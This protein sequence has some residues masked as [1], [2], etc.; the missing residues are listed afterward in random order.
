[1]FEKLCEA[2]GIRFKRIIPRADDKNADYKIS[3]HLNTLRL[4]DI[5]G[6]V[7]YLWGRVR[8][9]ANLI[10]SRLFA[11]LFL[12]LHL[13][14]P[15]KIRYQYIARLIDQAGQIYP[16]GRTYAGDAILFHALTQPEGIKPDPT[17]G[18]ANM[19]TGDLKIRNVAGTH[20]SIMMHEPHIAEL[21]RQIDDHLSQLHNPLPPENSLTEN[22]SL[23]SSAIL[24]VN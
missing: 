9:R 7:H 12:K 21:V 10:L 15:R 8:H 18:W 3:V 20:N 1:M 11:S 16:R 4:H 22:F 23:V 13:P 19:V 2:R 17:L 5:K 6:Q 24:N 14:L